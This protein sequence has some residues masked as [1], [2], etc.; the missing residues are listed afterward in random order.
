GAMDEFVE[1]AS[2]RGPSKLGPDARYRDLPA[3]QREVAGAEAALRAARTYA[4]AALADVDAHVAAGLP[5]ATE[6]RD[7]FFLAAAHVAQVAVDVVDTLHRA[8]GTASIFTSSHLQRALQDVHVAVAHV[9]L[10]PINLELVGRRLLG[11]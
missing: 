2:R 10:Q 4:L 11:S 8:A 3:V 5:T 9:S 7:A 6:E 1:L